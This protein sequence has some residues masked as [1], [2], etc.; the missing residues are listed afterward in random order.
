MIRQLIVLRR[1]DF[2]SALPDRS[3]AKTKSPE[4]DEKLL[5][6]VDE[7]LRQL[8]G[9]FKGPLNNLRIPLLDWQ[10]QLA[11]TPPQ[12]LPPL[13]QLVISVDMPDLADLNLF[14]KAVEDANRRARDQDKLEPVL[15]VGADLSV[16]ESEFFCPANVDEILFGDRNAAASLTESGVLRQR[17]LTGRGV[18]IVVI[19]QGFDATKVRNFGGGLANGTI[20][21]G[22]T[23][24]GHGL[25]MVRNI[26]D[27][28]PDATFYDVPLIPLRISDVPGF[29]S[30]ALHVFI[31][32]KQLIGFLRGTAVGPWDGPWVLVNAWSI[33]DRTTEVPLGDYTEKPAHPLNMLVDAIVDDAIDVVFAA[34]NCG[35]FCP[36]RRCGKRD[37][38]PGNSIYGANSH[39][40]VVTVGA[41]RTDTRWM[42]NSSQGPGQQ[43]LSLLKPDLCAPSYFRDVG[44][45]FIGNTAEPFVG[46]TGSPYIA[47]TGTSAA[48]GVAAGIIGAIR[49][50]WDQ[51]RLTPDDLRKA[52]NANARKTEGPTWNQ[53][54]GNG[55]INVRD[56]L[57]ALEPSAKR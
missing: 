13:D 24:R 40:R 46:N 21:P 30:T 41:V 6:R 1:D 25:M 38:G 54:L 32:L 35:Q 37:V 51:R 33:F 50:G 31:Q 29:I 18:N 16:S 28:A 20:G 39:P 53:R 57:S 42:G 27:V 36:D 8:L 17:G 9:D 44:D 3:T 22:T 11:Q 52:L 47:N 48:C 10:V 55:I 43:L 49:S 19:D 56:T 2:S 34:G 5:L 26:V 7:R 23:T 12:D 45:A 15:G 14:R 4:E